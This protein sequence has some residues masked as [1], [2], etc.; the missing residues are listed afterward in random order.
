MQVTARA[1][2]KEL[3]IMICGEKDAARNARSEL[4]Y[5][6]E[7]VFTE[8]EIAQFGDRTLSYELVDTDGNPTG[9]RTP[10]CGVKLDSEALDAI[11]GTD[12]YG[13]FI[14]GSTPHLDQAKEVFLALTQQ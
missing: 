8:D 12:E 4:F 3:D 1:A 10:A 14:V 9:E 11:Y 2:G 7:E 5:S 13:I 6:L